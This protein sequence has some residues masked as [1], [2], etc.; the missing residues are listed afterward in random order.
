MREVLGILS[1]E[2][3]EQMEEA[4]HDGVGREMAVKRAQTFTVIRSDRPGVDDSAI[5]QW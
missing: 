5:T 4:K 1:G 3:R 2:L